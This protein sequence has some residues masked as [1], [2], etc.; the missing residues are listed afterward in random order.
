MDEIWPKWMRSSQSGWDLT[1][2]GGDLAEWL[3]RLTANAVV[4]TVLGSIPTSSDTVESEGRK[5]KQC[6]ISYIKK[7]KKYNKSPFKRLCQYRQCYC[8]SFAAREVLTWPLKHWKHKHNHLLQSPFRLFVTWSNL[9]TVGNNRC[10]PSKLNEF[11]VGFVLVRMIALSI[12]R[13]SLK[14]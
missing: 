9:D 14:K 4:A 5:M 6:W 1:E 7:G 13:Q 10:K 3:E 11:Y 2:S 12:T 8:N